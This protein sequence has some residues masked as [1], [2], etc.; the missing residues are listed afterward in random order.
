MILRKMGASCR[1]ERGLFRCW[2]P[3]A[4]R[5]PLQ[6]ELENAGA[7]LCASIPYVCGR[8]CN[9]FLDMSGTMK[10]LF[11]NPVTVWQCYAKNV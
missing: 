1:C 8:S 9:Q 6:D 11:Y 4:Q 5:R 7:C 3:S 10:H 2:G